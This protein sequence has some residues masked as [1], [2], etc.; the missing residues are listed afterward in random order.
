ML[1]FSYENACRSYLGGIFIFW[2]RTFKNWFNILTG[3]GTFKMFKSHIDMWICEIL[4]Y[5]W[6]K[7]ITNFTS[8]I[9]KCSLNYQNIY[10]RIILI[11]LEN[12]PQFI[13]L[14]HILLLDGFGFTNGNLKQHFLQCFKS[15]SGEE[16]IKIGVSSRGHPC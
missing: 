5:I 4:F 7:S 12:V 14:I 1:S 8:M 16:R 3:G 2:R 13:G 15:C 9:Q 10:C 6:A 11:D